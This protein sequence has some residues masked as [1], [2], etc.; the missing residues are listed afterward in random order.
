MTQ[1]ETDRRKSDPMRIVCRRYAL[2]ILVCVL[3]SGSFHAREWKSHDAPGQHGA[4]FG[5]FHGKEVQRL[6]VTGGDV[7]CVSCA[8]HITKEN[9]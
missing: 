3:T 8:A 6:N 2:A 7:L 1:N 9:C 4:S 5:L